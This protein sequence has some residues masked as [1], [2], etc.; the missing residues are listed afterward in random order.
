MSYVLSCSEMGREI[1]QKITPL[2]S[3]FTIFVCKSNN[4]VETIRLTTYL[5]K[6]Q[7]FLANEMRTRYIL[8]WME[9]VH[10]SNL[11]YI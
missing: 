5:V 3:W 7:G 10:S 1:G 6:M 11:L 2:K 8:K 4:I 9:M